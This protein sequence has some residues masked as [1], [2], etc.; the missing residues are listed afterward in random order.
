MRDAGTSDVNPGQAAS[1]VKE[2]VLQLG[3][4]GQLV[5]IMS[6]PR[7]VRPG[8]PTLVML[9]AGLLHRVGPHRLHVVLGRRA[10]GLGLPSLRLDL[11]GIGDSVVSADATTFRESAVADARAAMDG[12]AAP[13]YVL[14]GVCAGADNAL[15]TALVDERVV[16]VVLVE[17]PAYVTRQAK[18]RAVRA[19][20]ADLGPI[21]AARWAIQVGMK[22]ASAGGPEAQGGEEGRTA[23]PAAELERQLR[24]LL[25]RGVAIFLVYSGAHGPRYNGEDQLFEVFPALRGKVERAWF[26]EANHTFTEPPAQADLVGAVIGWLG[27]RFR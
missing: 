6:H 18:V 26:P 11:G 16:G 7:T 20:V 15:A 1:D 17:P 5:G 27:E 21:A 10:A 25:D 19:K 13:R 4:D 3:R 12:V 2:Q 8:A 23:P 14:F 22:R 9:N 24:A